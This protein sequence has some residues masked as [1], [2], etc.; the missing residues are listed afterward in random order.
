MSGSLRPDTVVRTA[1]LL[2][3][4]K[5]DKEVAHIEQVTVRTV[6]RRV[7]RLMGALGASTRFQAG[8]L[9]CRQMGERTWNDRDDTKRSRPFDDISGGSRRAA[10]NQPGEQA[11]P[12]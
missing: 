2:A 4:G 8:Y 7:A 9:F 6:R 12:S 3:R 5:P 10:S 11:T 1:V